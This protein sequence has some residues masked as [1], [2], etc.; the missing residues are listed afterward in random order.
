M[1]EIKQPLINHWNV[2]VPA[3]DL[4][5]VIYGSVF[6]YCNISQNNALLKSPIYGTTFGVLY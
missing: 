2:S 1:N 3:L 4:L 5:I 6:T